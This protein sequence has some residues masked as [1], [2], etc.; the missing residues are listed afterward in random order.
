MLQQ[1]WTSKTLCWVKSGMKDHICITHRFPEKAKT[2]ISGCLQT[3]VNCKWARG[4]LLGWWKCSKTVLWWWVHTSVKFSTKY[5]LNGHILQIV[6][7]DFNE[8]FCKGNNTYLHC[9]GWFFTPSSTFENGLKKRIYFFK[10]VN[11]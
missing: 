10:K 6:N 7:C 5:I 3:G 1:E 9:D 8:I 4:P 2:W 11:C